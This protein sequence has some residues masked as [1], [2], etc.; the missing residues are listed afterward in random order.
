MADRIRNALTL[1]RPLVAV[2]GVRLR[3]HDTVLYNSLY[4]ADDELYVNPHIYG[5]AAPNAPVL[6][7]RRVDDAAMVSTYLESFERVWKRAREA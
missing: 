1:L 6:H 7:L 3:L 5:L 2:E 4:R